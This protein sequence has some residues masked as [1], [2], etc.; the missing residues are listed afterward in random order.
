MADEDWRVTVTLQT[1]AHTRRMLERLLGHEVAD[2]VRSKLGQRVAVGAGDSSIFLYAGSEEAA[3][4]AERVTRGLLA[5]QNLTADLALHR[6]HPA[7]EKWEDPS[8]P[9]PQ[10]AGQRDAEHQQ[11]VAEETRQSADTG[12]AQWEVR[13]DLPTHREAVALAAR[14]Q[15]EG[16]N[17]IRRWRFLVIG[18]ANEDEAGDLA[19]QISQEAP[20][21]ASVHQG[22]VP[23][24]FVNFGMQEFFQVLP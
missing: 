18:A 10:T 20:A 4:E 1:T 2:D 11:V 7:E 16:R 5:G 9:L 6:W 17:V 19:R 24:P 8:V 14:L 15:A 23:R 13:V 22:S 3:R 12:L 21:G